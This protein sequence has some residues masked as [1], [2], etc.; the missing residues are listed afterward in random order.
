MTIMATRA[1][2]FL[3]QK[4]IAFE[5]IKYKHDEKGAA[6]AATATGSP[7]EQTVKTLVADTG[8]KQ[9]VLVLLPGDK[10]VSMKK[11]ASALG[12]KR[13]GMAAAETAERLT[14]YLTGGISPFGTKQNIPV[15]MEERI[16]DFDEVLINAGQRGMM[17]AISPLDIRDVLRC[18]VARIVQ[19]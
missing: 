17:I 1:I 10:Q 5:I 16:L 6:F 8:K 3:K 15:I 14:G 18:T 7:L 11:L 12:A 2:Q 19:D 4:K 9:F 13:A